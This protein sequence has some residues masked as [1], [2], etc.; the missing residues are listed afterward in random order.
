MTQIITQKQLDLFNQN[1]EIK[2]LRK[3]TD[4]TEH[5]RLNPERFNTNSLEN[6]P[7]SNS[8]PN[9][10]TEDYKICFIYNKNKELD[11]Q[12]KIH[13]IANT[14][15]DVKNFI[16]NEMENI[17]NKKLEQTRVQSFRGKLELFNQ[18]F[19]IHFVQSK[20]YHHGSDE[21]TFEDLNNP[22]PL[23]DAINFEEPKDAYCEILES[24][25][26]INKGT[27]LIRKVKTMNEIAYFIEN[28]MDNYL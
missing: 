9:Y 1:F 21:L 16:I 10:S 19:T 27:E 25:H 17:L 26:T 14:M 3:N 11:N 23:Q 28:E 5:E 15:Q 6:A 7:L 2:M 18:N 4:Y 22:L 13:S 24:Y 20:E 12:V 8:F